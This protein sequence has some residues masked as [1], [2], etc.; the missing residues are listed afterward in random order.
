MM[1]KVSTLHLV[2]FQ[3]IQS[4]ATDNKVFIKTD[5]P[6]AGTTGGTTNIIKS[7]DPLSPTTPFRHNFVTGDKI[8]WNNSYN[9][10]LSTGV[11]FVTNINDF[12]FQLSYSASDVFGWTV[13]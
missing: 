6:Q 7:V 13:Y 9:S 12:D 3:T 8:Y 4:L 11:Y 5:P 10:G 2:V 1:N